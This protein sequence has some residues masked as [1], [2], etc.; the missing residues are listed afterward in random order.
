MVPQDVDE[1]FPQD[2]DQ[3]S[4]IE[5]IK[6][7][8]EQQIR[9]KTLKEI[10]HRLHQRVTGDEVAASPPHQWH[11]PINY[12]LSSQ[13]QA[14]QGAD[15][16]TYLPQGHSLFPPLCAEIMLELGLQKELKQLTHLLRT[17]QHATM[18]RA[19][20]NALRS[21]NDPTT[22]GRSRL[23]KVLAEI[24]Q[25]KIDGLGLQRMLNQAIERL[26]PHPGQ[27][28]YDKWRIRYDILYLT[29]REKKSPQIVAATLALSERQYYRE[30]KG[31]IEGIIGYL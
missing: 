20:R 29:Y 9:L 26:N 16:G 5:L 11:C 23:A 21:L 17:E 18:E 24:R 30:L 27:P 2:W 8:L 4:R 25:I 22:L 13:P 15:K 28:G 3:L 31:A 19:I 7:V 12:L 14:G 10:L 6:L 1:S